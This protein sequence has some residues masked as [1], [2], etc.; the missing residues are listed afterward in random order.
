MEED[1]RVAITKSDTKTYRR[2]L[3]DDYVLQ[4]L[5]FATHS[6]DST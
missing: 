4:C 1:L 2:L 6:R 5:S 3:G